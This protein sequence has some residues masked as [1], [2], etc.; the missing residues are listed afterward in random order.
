MSWPL[1]ALMGVVVVA[2]LWKYRDDYRKYGRTTILGASA[3]LAV[4]FM[5]NLIVG[6]FVPWIGLP[7]TALQA[8]GFVLITAGS[9]AC[10]VPTIGFRSAKKVVGMEPGGLEVSG[11]YRYSRNPQYIGYGL[12]LLGWALCG[13]SAKTFV[14]V[15][16]YWVVV[17][18]TILIEEEH[19]IEV[20]GDAY[21]DYKDSTPRYLFH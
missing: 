5:P 12:F 16:L 9:M 1:V 7:A 19:L 15:A 8:V 20:F 10:L 13:H 11:L 14:G 6:L 2:G 17:H 18:L 21:K 3:I 4:F